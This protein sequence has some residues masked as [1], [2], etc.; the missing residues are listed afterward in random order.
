[1]SAHVNG[2]LVSGIDR[3]TVPQDTANYDL[4][5]VGQYGKTNA[6]WTYSTTLA[7]E[8]PWK[9]AKSDTRDLLGGVVNIKTTFANF[10]NFWPEYSSLR[11]KTANVIEVLSA[12]PYRVGDKV[13]GQF[14]TILHYIF[15]CPLTG[16]RSPHALRLRR[17][18]WQT[19][20][21]H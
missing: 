17:R 20:P 19:I 15:Y 9:S 14:G 7:K 12:L 10:L 13:V 18:D 6:A 2:E 3:R 5:V 21:G 16:A 1:M 4:A 8:D 11:Y